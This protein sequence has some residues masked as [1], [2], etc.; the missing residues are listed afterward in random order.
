[1]KKN[2][3][4]AI[5]LFCGAGGLSVGL[6]KAGFRVVAGVEVDEVAA[7]S[8]RMNHRKHIL[9]CEDIRK[10]SEEHTSELQSH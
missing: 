2:K 1:M 6:K 7:A 10:R 5:D 3:L 8:Y 9:Y 4:T